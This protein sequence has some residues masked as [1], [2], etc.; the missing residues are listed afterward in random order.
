LLSSRDER[1]P[2]TEWGVFELY[3]TQGAN[4]LWH[5]SIYQSIVPSI[6]NRY[7]DVTQGRY[8]DYSVK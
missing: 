6:C 3:S 5:R 1:P 4:N 7:P 8:H 2:L